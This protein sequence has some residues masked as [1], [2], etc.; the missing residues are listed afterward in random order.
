MGSFFK[1][2]PHI[3]FGDFC[4]TTSP[5]ISKLHSQVTRASMLDNRQNGD[6]KFT[7]LNFV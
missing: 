1:F 5:Q 6:K 4:S 2:K 7:I 3:V